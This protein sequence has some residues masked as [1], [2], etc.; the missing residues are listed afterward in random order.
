MVSEITVAI[1]DE[2]KTLRTK[3]LI[4]NIYA[5]DE[6]DP[7]I[8]ECVKKTLENFSGDPDQITVTIKMEL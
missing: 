6:E 7:V 2:E 3:Y 1:K 4:Y 8:Q 5:V